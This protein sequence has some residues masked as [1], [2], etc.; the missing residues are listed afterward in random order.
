MHHGLRK[1]P[2]AGWTRLACL[3]L[4]LLSGALGAFDI[5]HEVLL[6]LNT[7]TSSW[8]DTLKEE[9]KVPQAPFGLLHSKTTS[10]YMVADRHEQ[11][12][13]CAHARAMH[14]QFAMR[15][16][17]SA[18]LC[19]N[20]TRHATKQT[21]PSRRKSVPQAKPSR[22]KS[23]C[24]PNFFLNGEGCLPLHHFNQAIPES[25]DSANDILF[26]SMLLSGQKRRLANG[27][28]CLQIV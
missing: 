1:R 10:I 28:R 8:H 4:P 14:A 3:M 18:A 11:T 2:D 13:P 26:R 25:Q 15:N 9:C 21:F 23:F 20:G 17:C 6:V 24:L 27:L 7:V 16:G 19:R 5:R 22:P 12:P